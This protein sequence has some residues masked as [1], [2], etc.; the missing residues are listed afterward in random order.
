MSPVPLVNIK[1]IS[2]SKKKNDSL[3]NNHKA[4][5]PVH[6]SDIETTAESLEFNEF[7]EIA[8]SNNIPTMKPGSKVKRLKR[9][10]QEAEDKRN[11]LETLQ[12]QGSAGKELAKEEL[13]SDALV[14]A[15]GSKSVTDTGKLRK[16]LKKIEKSK[17]KSSKE[18]QV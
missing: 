10:L 5:V 7:K 16:A 4:K 3:Q 2:L 17:E 11:R 18:W 13:W 8:S 14:D 1:N 9:M 6:N 12:Q 15:S